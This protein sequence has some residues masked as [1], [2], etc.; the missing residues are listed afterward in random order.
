MSKSIFIKAKNYNG[1]NVEELINHLKTLPKNKRVVV[2][3][4]DGIEPLNIIQD[5]FFSY[6]HLNYKNSVCLNSFYEEEFIS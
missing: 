4:S 2:N 1:F 5:S 6:P 3:T